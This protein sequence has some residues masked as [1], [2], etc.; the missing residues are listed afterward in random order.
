MGLTVGIDI[1]GTFT[2]T[3]VIDDSGRVSVC[4]CTGCLNIGKAIAAAEE[5]GGR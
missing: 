4:R 3:V 1:G 2:D 5:G